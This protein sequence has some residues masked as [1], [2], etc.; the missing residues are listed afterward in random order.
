MSQ[1]LEEALEAIRKGERVALATIVQSK[2]S[3]PRATGAK[4]LV[5][6]DGAPKGTIGGGEM[7][8][9]VIKEA[10]AVLKS[11]QPR[12]L[13]YSFREVEEGGVG[14]CGGENDVF[15]DVLGPPRQLLIVGAGHVGQAVAE[16]GC[17]LGLDCIVMDHRAEFANSE[18]FPRARQIL[19]DDVVK[20]LGEYPINQQT[21]IVIV[22]RGHVQDIEALSAVI[23]C[24]AAYIGMIGSRRKTERV[25]EVM[26]AQ[27][28]EQALLNKVHAPIGLDIGAETPE[29]IAVSIAGQIIALMHGKLRDA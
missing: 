14:I 17:F 9:Q 26:R 11:G 13:H 4:M 16:L 28:V 6:L 23:H 7:E 3:T 27:G 19:L 1:L 20:S 12:L 29:E 25:F 24:P 10:L 18:R 15:I 5:F 22:T 8:G 2:G 21:Y